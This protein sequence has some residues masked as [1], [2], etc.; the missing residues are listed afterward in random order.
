MAT[1]RQKKAVDNL[2]ENRGNVSLAM[3][4][5]GYDLTT[6]KNPK[7]LTESKGFQELMAEYG[8]TKGLITRALV[9]DIN[10]KPKHRILELSLGADILGMKKQDR[11]SMLNGASIQNFTQIVI[12]PPHERKII[13]DK[14]D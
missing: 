13:T 7:N 1:I 4:D 8:L 3:K 11:S 12:N 5:A 9:D 6:A 14:S 2:V 10:A